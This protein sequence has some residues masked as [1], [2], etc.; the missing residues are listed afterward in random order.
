MIH[1]HVDK[2]FSISWSKSKRGVPNL[3]IDGRTGNQPWLV[4]IYS[5]DY[6]FTRVG[7]VYDVFDNPMK[8]IN[9]IRARLKNLRAI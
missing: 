9:F 7:S 8:V 1:D 6:I 5:D 4:S 2:D 3:Q